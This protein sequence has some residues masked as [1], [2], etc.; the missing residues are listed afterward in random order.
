MKEQEAIIEEFLR[1]NQFRYYREDGDYL[2]GIRGQN[3]N[4]KIRI[5]LDD[6]RDQCLVM[7]SFPNFYKPEQL[8]TLARIF[9]K[10]NLETLYTKLFYDPEDGEAYC[11][12]CGIS[13]SKYF[14]TDVIRSYT[15]AISSVIDDVYEEINSAEK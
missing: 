10:R 12:C 7:G 4:I 6:E 11:N 3:C 1:E 13:I 2:F 9:N 15:F 8:P 14:S 5:S